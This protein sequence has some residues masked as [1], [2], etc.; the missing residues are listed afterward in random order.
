MDQSKNRKNGALLLGMYI[1]LLLIVLFVPILST[2]AIFLLPVPF[3]IYVARYGF[4]SAMF[5]IL[6]ALV[7]SIL[8]GAVFTVPVTIFMACGGVMI[9]YSIHKQATA[10]QT[11][12]NGAAGFV[13]GFILLA[14][15]S[16]FIF[17]VNIVKVVDQTMDDS[18]AVSQG[19]MKQFGMEGQT[20]KET[21]LIKEQIDY[22][23]NLFPV[24]LAVIITLMAW[25]VQW[26]SYKLL[27]RKEVN[28][29][30]FP[31]FRTFQLP[32]GFIWLYFFTM[33]FAFFNMEPGETAFLFAQNIYM[34]VGLFIVIH[35]YSFLFFYADHKKI[36]KI[37]PILVIILTL[38]FPAF[39]YLIRIIAI[40]DMSLRIRDRIV[41]K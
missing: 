20:E 21:T 34:F 11:L 19:F 4:K 12:A 14:L 32:G 22:V 37:I 31:A 9:G 35:G 39:L 36:P 13:F 10:Y 5:M 7:F 26:I 18:I 2:I 33:I 24:I 40:F 1:S 15:I 23:K 28:K 6:G 25:F 8:F 16:Q 41:K 29:L 27:N 17:D 3:V 30:R 38:L